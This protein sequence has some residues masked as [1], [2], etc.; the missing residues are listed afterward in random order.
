MHP[1][2]RCVGVSILGSKRSQT[3]YNQP[4]KP[5]IH[6]VLKAYNLFRWAQN[7]MANQQ[8]CPYLNKLHVQ[9]DSSFVCFLL[10]IPWKFQLF[11]LFCE[12]V[13]AFMSSTEIFRGEI[14]VRPARIDPL[15]H[16]WRLAAVLFTGPAL[17][18]CYHVG[19]YA[20]CLYRSGYRFKLQS[21]LNITRYVV[22]VFRRIF[23]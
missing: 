16:D 4:R 23:H 12:T 2:C 18:P 21:L 1:F 7:R 22:L 17:L 14:G 5:I 13:V 3:N 8:G 9:K 19:L 15:T 10:E 6:G 20:Y 11:S